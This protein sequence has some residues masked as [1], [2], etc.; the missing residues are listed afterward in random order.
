[1][2]LALKKRCEN[3]L[4]RRWRRQ[5]H[6]NISER[7][8]RKMVRKCE[9]N[10][11]PYVRLHA[12]SSSA[13]SKR[14]NEQQLNCDSDLTEYSPCP[15]L[16]PSNET[17][18]LVCNPMRDNT[19]R[20]ETTHEA[21]GTR[22]RMF[23][24]CDQAVL[25]SGGWN[26]QTSLSRHSSNIVNVYHLLRRNGFNQQGIKVFFANGMHRGIQGTCCWLLLPTQSM[27]FTVANDAACSI[28]LLI[29]L[30]YHTHC[31]VCFDLRD[32]TPPLPEIAGFL[33][34]TV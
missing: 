24:S 22:C 33:S 9:I 25:I 1:M 11:I 23:E 32:L 10:F 8:V 31:Y 30:A 13:N 3:A 34:G 5:N 14:D 29:L 12:S 7:L 2:K 19:R 4:H 20:C 15:S 16:R 6:N 26:R 27:L 18:E 21:V 28:Y 17:L